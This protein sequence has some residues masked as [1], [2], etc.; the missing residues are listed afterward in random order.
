NTGEI[1]R[2]DGFVRHVRR[3]LNQFAGPQDQ[4]FT[5]NFEMERSAD[6]VT[7]LFALVLM[8]RND[9]AFLDRQERHGDFFACEKPAR[10]QIGDVLFG[11]FVQLVMLHLILLILLVGVMRREYSCYQRKLAIEEA[12][13]KRKGRWILSIALFLQSSCLIVLSVAVAPVALIRDFLPM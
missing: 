3:N 12:N 13:K 9:R 1:F 8:Q 5:A 2:R 4:F 7:E 10:E 11:D 6:A